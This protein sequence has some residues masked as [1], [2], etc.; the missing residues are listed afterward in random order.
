MIST[1]VVAV[2]GARGQIL[3]ARPAGEEMQAEH[4][5]YQIEYGDGVGPGTTLILHLQPAAL[6]DDTLQVPADL[7]G[8]YLGADGCCLSAT[9]T[10][11]RE[12]IDRRQQVRQWVLA[13]WV[14]APLYAMALESAERVGRTR[15][16][17]RMIARAA[18][19]DATLADAPWGKLAAAMQVT[20]A[21][22]WRHH[23][24]EWADVSAATWY[25]YTA[26][27][28]PSADASIAMP[29]ASQTLDLIAWCQEVA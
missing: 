2:V 17:V 10:H 20:V 25:D 23:T 18:T 22:Y 11:G 12:V 15:L 1:A 5:Q 14:G 13:E 24:S 8:R 3:A 19:V 26:D 27:G 28:R 16:W 6:T 9:P 4:D 29:P 7:V 21:T